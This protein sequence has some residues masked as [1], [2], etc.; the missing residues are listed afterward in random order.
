MLY[1]GGVRPLV[2]RADTLTATRDRHHLR[3][4]TIVYRTCIPPYDFHLESLLHLPGDQVSFT[5]LTVSQQLT[6]PF[7][8]HSD[9][10]VCVWREV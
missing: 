3:C 1:V 6:D 2:R 9:S 7:T 4:C 8:T 5:T 10:S